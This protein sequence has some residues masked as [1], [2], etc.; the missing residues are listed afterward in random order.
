MTTAL[1]VEPQSG[2]HTLSLSPPILAALDRANY[3]EPTPIQ[4]AFIPPALSGRD[5]IGQ[6]Q[7]GT[8]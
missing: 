7:T 3:L 1:L 5:V 8:G 6:A 2:F 4:A